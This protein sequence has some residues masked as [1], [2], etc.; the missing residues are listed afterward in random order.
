MSNYD[1]TRHVCQCCHKW[2]AVCDEL[3]GKLQAKEKEM[4]EYQAKHNI[5]LRNQPEAKAG[6]K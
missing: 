3:Y 1:L 4:Q 2:Q 5:R 6:A